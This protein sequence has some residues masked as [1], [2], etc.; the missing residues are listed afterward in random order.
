MKL[1]LSSNQAVSLQHQNVKTKIYIS[2][3]R[4]E[5]LRQKKKHFA[6]FLNG[7]HLPKTVSDLRVRLQNQV[8]LDRLDCS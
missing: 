3:E 1:T 7:F 5:V 2:S 6:S 4:E 8:D